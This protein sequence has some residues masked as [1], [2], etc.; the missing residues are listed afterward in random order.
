MVALPPLRVLVITEDASQQAQPSLHKIVREALKI[1]DEHISFDPRRCTL[2]PLR[3]SEPAWLAAIANRWKE[4]RPSANTAHLFGRIATRISEEG[5]FVVFHFDSDTQWSRRDQSENRQKF[6]KIVRTGVEQALRGVVRS[7]LDRRPPLAL[8]EAEIARRLGR[9]F[10]FAPCYSIESWLYQ[11][12]SLVGV[13]CA[14]AHHGDSG[15]ARAHA[16]RIRSWAADP[17]LLDDLERPK[18][19]ALSC[20]GDRSNE[21]LAKGFP[22]ADV[23]FADRS[24][25]E[26]V[27]RMEKCE[28]LRQCLRATYAG[29]AIPPQSA[30]GT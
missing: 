20:V 6:E 14:A 11:N 2:D 4:R 26:A 13:K 8:D 22:A 12:T 5:G 17:T 15:M 30:S 1:V 25:T 10:I 29:A 16:E 19:D 24:F 23:Y 18:D 9:L 3:E 7:P 28:A 27:T 21:E